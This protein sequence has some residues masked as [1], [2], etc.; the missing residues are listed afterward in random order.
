MSL[1]AQTFSTFIAALALCLATQ[2]PSGLQSPARKDN[3]GN[4][5]IRGVVTY[6]DTGHPVRYAGVSLLN[7]ETGTWAGDGIANRRGEFTFDNVAAGNYIVSVNF[8]GV[9]QPPFVS[10]YSGSTIA[11][12]R[13]L[14][15]TFT[16]VVVNGTDSVETTV[17]AVR[18][19]VITGRVVTDDDQPLINADINLLKRENGAWALVGPPWNRHSDD[20]K[21]K[22]DPSGV[23]R[24]AGLAAGEYLVRVSEGQVSYDQISQEDGAFSNGFLMAAYYPAATNVKD[25]ETVTVVEGSESTGIDIRVPDRA[26]HKISG[27]LTFGPDNQPGASAQI[28]IERTDEVGYS[29]QDTPGAMVR[30]DDQGRWEI[31]GVP[32]GEYL[33]QI[34][35]SLQVGSEGNN[36][37]YV[38][39]APKRFSVRVEHEDVIVPDTR[40]S[41]GS[42]ITGK[43]TLDGKPPKKPY[44]LFPRAISEKEISAVT[45]RDSSNQWTRGTSGHVRGDGTF[46]IYGLS[47]DKYSI[48]LWGA[49]EQEYYVKSI[50]RKGVDLRKSLLKVGDES[51]VENVIIALA[52]DFATI[53]GQLTRPEAS[54]KLNLREAVVILAPANDATRRLGHGLTFAQ[55]DA[56]GKFAI[57]CP[58]GE[59]FLT[60]LTSGK[61][62]S[63]AS[64][65]DEKYFKDDQQKFQRVTVKGNEKLKDLTLAVGAN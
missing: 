30:S 48:G 17:R 13:S 35:G 39:I 16:E 63:L 38:T 55:P 60:A 23:Y 43:V 7:S 1:T 4:S 28:S 21:L 50:T 25:A 62:K 29:N 3:Q 51:S 40:L 44:Q 61:I 11:Q 10:R 20:K 53:E 33:I 24:I 15:E 47:A 65:I 56:R 2:I 49:E 26:V 42:S 14:G 9:L 34:G 59:Y 41:E 8:P 5:T 18:G 46:W 58:P 54:P 27:K 22:T 45:P 19:G 57:A 6:A 31:E 12:L 36:D 32:P 52:S 37:D 64:P